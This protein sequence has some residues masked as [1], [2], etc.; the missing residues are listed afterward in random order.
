M[1]KI[2][3][4]DTE[5]TGLDSVKNGIIQIA[6]LVENKKG[7]VIDELNL[8]MK[9]FK[10]CVYD[11]TALETNGKTDADIA[12]YIPEKDAFK[13]LVEF[14]DKHINKFDKND[15]FTPAGYNIPFDIAFLQALFKRNDNDFYGAYFNYYDVDTYA[16][17]KILDLVGTFEDKPSKKLIA[18]CDKFGIELDEA[19]AHDALADIKATRKL[20]KRICKGYL[21]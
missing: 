9:P 4:F 5:T 18:V 19:D 6:M 2:L 16:L 13:T 3:W 14:L 20:H 8:R 12:Q 15:K 10:G 7:K 17:V 11:E 21:K 1:R